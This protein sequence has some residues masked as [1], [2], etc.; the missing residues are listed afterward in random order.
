MKIQTLLG[1]CLSGS[2]LFAGSAAMADDN[3]SNN[4][5]A[6]AV[7]VHI[8]KE[9]RKTA[10]DDSDAAVASAVATQTAIASD[11][12]KVMP[13]ENS[14]VQ[15]NADGSMSAQ[16]GS[17]NLKYLVMTVDEDGTKSVTHQSA[18]KLESVSMTKPTKSGE[19]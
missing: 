15:Y 14:D 1:L 4:R 6:R 9:G 10:P 11:V 7:Q 17:S 18:D 13:A 16:L 5:S 2:L 19:K 12:S 8:D 3:K